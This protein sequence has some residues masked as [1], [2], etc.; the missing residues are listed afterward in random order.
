MNSEKGGLSSLERQKKTAE[1]IARR[2]VLEAYEKSGVGIVKDVIKKQEEKN[3]LGS[4][5]GANSTEVD[6]KYKA[7]QIKSVSPEEWRKYH[8]AWQNYYQKYYSDYYS[9]AAKDYVAK[10]K[11]KAERLK[12]EEAEAAK[13][14]SKVDNF[15][16]DETGKE[17]L[18]KR[19]SNTL[20]GKLRERASEKA[21]REKRRRRMTPIIAGVAVVFLVLFLQYNRLIFAPIMAYVSPGDSPASEISAVDPTI[22]ATN[23][24]DEE[25]LIIPKLNVEV[26]I[27]FGVDLDGVMSAMNSG[28]VHYRINGANAYPGQIGNFVITGHSAGDIYSANPYKFIFSGLERLED[29]DMIYVHYKSKRYSYKVAKK[30]VIEPTEVSKLVYETEKPM[31]TLVTCTPLGTSRYRLLVTAE[32]ISP[33]YEKAE[34]A[35]SEPEEETKSEVLP[36][37][38]KTFFERVWDWLT[39]KN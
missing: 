25:V 26:P 5:T 27:A 36:Q 29:G 10:E 13:L 12:A 2:K 23:V 38:E 39:G 6:N 22:V 32:Q 33:N 3:T 24:P 31:L 11:L 19:L 4:G 1:E 14:V 17:E 28:V 37:N 15:D 30:E 21:K 18:T 34:V 8:S 16:K 20:K 35:K 9:K 7:N